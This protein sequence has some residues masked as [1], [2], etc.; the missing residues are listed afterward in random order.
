M[1]SKSANKFLG[2]LNTR[3]DGNIRVEHLEH[4]LHPRFLGIN[5]R[6][7]KKIPKEIG[8]LKML[9]TL[10]LSESIILELPSSCSLPTQLVCL[11]IVFDYTLHNPEMFSV[12]R[13]TSL[14]E[15][16]IQFNVWNKAPRKLVKELGSLRELR[17]L[18]GKMR[19]R[20]Y[21]I[22]WSLY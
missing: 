18:D 6:R 21:E 12:G 9:Q 14:E 10:D 5:G 16:S 19:R 8:A 1:Q 2:V 11:R 15:L 17:V 4:L 7:I 20:A 13:L 3:Y 22:C